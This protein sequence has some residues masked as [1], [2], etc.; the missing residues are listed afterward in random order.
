MQTVADRN[1]DYAGTHCLLALASHYFVDEPDDQLT[2]QTE[3]EQCLALDAPA[4]VVPFVQTV[5]D[6]VAGG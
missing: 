3:G 1:P 2:H 4:D 5:L 6:E